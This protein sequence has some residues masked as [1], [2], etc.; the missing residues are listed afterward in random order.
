MP[1][2]GSA[3]AA[4]IG[5]A[6]FV[7]RNRPRYLRYAKARL[8]REEISPVTVDGGPASAAVSTALASTRESWGLILSRPCPA[9]EVWQELRLRVSQEAGRA[10]PK[11][12]ALTE[13]YRQLSDGFADIVVLCC[14][15]GFDIEE[16]AELM[17]TEAPAV[18]TA[19]AVVRRRLPHLVEGSGG[20]AP[21]TRP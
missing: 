4:D 21:L 7:E 10:A 2:K 17:G 12:P 6:A 3:A 8:S 18:H 1:T 15:L 11:D 16:A 20:E 5:F 19:L 14:R 13:L 9:A